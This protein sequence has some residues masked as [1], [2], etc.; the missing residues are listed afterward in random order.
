MMKRVQFH[1]YFL[2]NNVSSDYA[3]LNMHY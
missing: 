1:I 3:I 2:P